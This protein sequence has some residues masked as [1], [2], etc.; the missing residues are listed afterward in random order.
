MQATSHRN[1]GVVGLSGS[2]TEVD[3]DTEKLKNVD[4]GI[5]EVLSSVELRFGELRVRSLRA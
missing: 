5:E 3:V 2:V 1:V 4:I